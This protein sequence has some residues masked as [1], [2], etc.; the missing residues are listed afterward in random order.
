M[1]LPSAGGPGVI[2]TAM[3]RHELD[4]AV[5][6]EFL[7]RLAASFVTTAVRTGTLDASEAGA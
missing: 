6:T 2:S 3:G 4:I 1:T 7:L 5:V